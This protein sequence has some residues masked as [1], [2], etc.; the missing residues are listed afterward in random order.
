MRC[1]R[2][3]FVSRAIVIDPVR[4]E[5]HYFVCNVWMACNIGD[6]RVDRTFKVASDADLHNAEHLFFTHTNRCV[7]PC[8]QRN[9]KYIFFS[10]EVFFLS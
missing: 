7:R 5:T 9:S 8:F 10:S 1:A 6:G 2:Y 3:R 4:L